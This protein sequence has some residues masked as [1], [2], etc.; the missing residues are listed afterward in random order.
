[1]EKKS[2]SEETQL[3]TS[4]AQYDDVIHLDINQAIETVGC[5]WSTLF[6]TIG[7]FMIFALE[8]L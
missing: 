7:P 5:G 2:V 3:V 6:M 4:S 8:G 1:M